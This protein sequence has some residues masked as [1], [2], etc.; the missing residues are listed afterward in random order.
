[1]D[2]SKAQAAQSI[3]SFQLLYRDLEEA[4]LALPI[5]YLR[6]PQLNLTFLRPDTC[7]FGVQHIRVPL[8]RMHPTAHPQQG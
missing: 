7:L 1:M 6:P 5:S 3:I 4:H 2:L 8:A